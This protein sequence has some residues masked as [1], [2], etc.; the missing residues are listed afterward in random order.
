MVLDRFRVVWGKDGG[1]HAEDGASRPGLLY[2]SS[3]IRDVQMATYSSSNL[4]RCIDSKVLM[5]DSEV[6]I[7]TQSPMDRDARL[8]T[9]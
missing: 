1:N 2:A 7:T 5:T 4:F 9:I 8:T 6:V 3:R